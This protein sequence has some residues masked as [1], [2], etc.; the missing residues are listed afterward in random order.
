M[1]AT[2]QLILG[3]DKRNALFTVYEREQDDGEEQLHVYYGLELLEGP[4]EIPR[5]R[6]AGD[7]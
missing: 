2:G 3:T 7:S 1:I 4:S 5:V 6:I